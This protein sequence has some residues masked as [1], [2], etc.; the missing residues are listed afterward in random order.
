[1]TTSFAWFVRGNIPA[2]FYV[3]PMGAVLALLA[4]MTFW[5]AACIALT[6]RP[7]HR[8]LSLVRFPYYLVPLFAGFVIGWAWKIYIHL[9]HA[10]GWH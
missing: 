2:S 4:A 1:M 10:D 5:A 9:H 7:F 8:L 3:Q 6:G